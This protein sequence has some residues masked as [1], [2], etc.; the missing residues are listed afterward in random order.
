VSDISI[1]TPTEVTRGEGG[2]KIRTGKNDER[3]D[4][5]QY[6]ILC[7]RG[8][9]EKKKLGKKGDRSNKNTKGGGSS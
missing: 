4:S 6:C 3:R 7:G 9:K 1:W 5:K 8:K 2:K